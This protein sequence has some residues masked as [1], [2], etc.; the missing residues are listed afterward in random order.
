M[1][2]I[3]IFL[4]D[5]DIIHGLN[6]RELELYWRAGFFFYISFVKQILTASFVFFNQLKDIK[7]EKG[8]KGTGKIISE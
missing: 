2:N 8:V 7:K 1:Y 4:W 6:K 3:H 5:L